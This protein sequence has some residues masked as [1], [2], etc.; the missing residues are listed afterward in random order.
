MAIQGYS[1]LLRRSGASTAVTDEAVSQVTGTTYR[2]TA[3]ARRCIDPD[4]TW[5][6]EDDNVAIAYSA[7]VSVDYA[8]GVFVLAAPP[9]GAVTFTGSYL[10]LTTSAEVIVDAR[11]FGLNESTDLLDTTVMA[12]TTS[13]HAAVRRRVTGLKDAELTV[14]SIAAPSAHSALYTL[15]QS[16]DPVVTEVFFG[17]DAAPRFRGFC[18]LDGIEVSGDVGDLIVANLSF[19]IAAIRNAAS[20]FVASYS[21]RSLT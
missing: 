5:V 21:Y 3:E 2:I 7:I 18:K 14:E 10:P 9:G 15:M 20:G 1:C 19:K 4:V 11:S 12:G 8:H 6:L 17:T 13:L 16:G